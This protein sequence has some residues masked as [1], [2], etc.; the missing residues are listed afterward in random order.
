MLYFFWNIRIFSNIFLNAPQKPDFCI[1]KRVHIATKMCIQNIFLRKLLYT[2]LTFK[3]RTLAI[4][5]LTAICEKGYSTNLVYK[6]VE[7]SPTYAHLPRLPCIAP[8][9]P[10]KIVEN[11]SVSTL[12]STFL[13]RLYTLL[14]QKVML[15]KTFGYKWKS[16]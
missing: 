3:K 4:A 1:Q 9:N 6:C 13:H 10:S 8:R 5:T 15:W 12:D 14:L 2:K 11:S 16:F 7:I